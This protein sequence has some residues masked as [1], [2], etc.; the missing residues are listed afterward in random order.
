MLLDVLGEETGLRFTLG[1]EI[2]CIQTGT[3]EMDADYGIRAYG[4]LPE[5]KPMILIFHPDRF[6]I[7]IAQDFDTVER[8][9]S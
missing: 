1:G 4:L 3:Y 2:F 7:E 8:L 6:K 5:H 9:L